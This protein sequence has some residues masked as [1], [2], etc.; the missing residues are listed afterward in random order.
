MQCDGGAECSQCSQQHDVLQRVTFAVADDTLYHPG[1][2]VPGESGQLLFGLT[3][4]KQFFLFFHFFVLIAFFFAIR[5]FVI[6]Y[7]ITRARV[8]GKIMP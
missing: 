1:P 3:A 7:L 4:R 5:T 8:C 2:L 6:L